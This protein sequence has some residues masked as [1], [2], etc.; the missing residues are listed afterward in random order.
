ML[1]QLNFHGMPKDE[2]TGKDGLLRQLTSM[3]YAAGG[4]YVAPWFNAKE[5]SYLVLLIEI[6]ISNNRYA[7]IS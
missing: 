3:V 2:L 6:G 1:D 5:H 7:V 4:K